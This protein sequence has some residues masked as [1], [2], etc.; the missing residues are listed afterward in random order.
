[1]LTPTVVPVW[2]DGR[3]QVATAWRGTFWRK[4]LPEMVE[5]II[6]ETARRA[7]WY[8]QATEPTLATAEIVAGY[9]GRRA[10]EPAIQQANAL[11]LARYHG[12]TARG[13]RRWPL[14]LC[15]THSLLAL[16]ALGALSLDLPE[17]GWPWYPREDTAGQQRRRFL[18]ALAQDG[19]FVPEGGL[20]QTPPKTRRTA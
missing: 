4:G 18:A 5:I 20:G 14:P 3:W 17:L 1:L 6:V 16:L 11:G 10:I 7:P 9:H 12:R 8:L 13:V 19:V 2:V 15:L